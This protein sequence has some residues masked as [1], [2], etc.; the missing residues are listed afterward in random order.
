MGDS[1][2]KQCIV[3]IDDRKEVNEC[4]AKC[5]AEDILKLTPE[6]G[7]GNSRS[8]DSVD[9]CD[10]T[11]FRKC[12]IVED[13]DLDIILLSVCLY[14]QDIA[15]AKNMNQKEMKKVQDKLAEIKND[16]STV[17]PVVDVCL[18]KDSVRLDGAWDIKDFIE[19]FK[20][21]N[22]FP[23]KL[24]VSGNTRALDQDDFNSLKME[25]TLFTL[26]PIERD[27]GNGIE[28]DKNES[29][30]STVEDAFFSKILQEYKTQKEEEFETFS[31][32]A[33]EIIVKL[34]HAST[35]YDKF[36]STI[37]VANEILYYFQ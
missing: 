1:N 33:K 8:E 22:N 20:K 10:Y 15:N 31:R 7:N 32:A 12:K 23:I 5:L 4:Q 35:K 18:A 26:R 9:S 3:F 29:W 6:G 37:F 36:F 27:L 21:L 28:L 30:R 2:K 13:R 24:L 11:V 14:T 19:F 17:L 25:N 16:Y 34:I